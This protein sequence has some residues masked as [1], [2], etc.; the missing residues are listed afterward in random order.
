M[1]NYLHQ[2][3]IFY[4]LL[5]EFCLQL[6][7]KLLISRGMENINMLH[8]FFKALTFLLFSLSSLLPMGA[9]A[10]TTTKAK[11]QL[12]ITV[13]DLPDHGELPAGWT[14]E[15]LSAKFLAAFK[16]HHLTGVYGFV[17]SHVINEDKPELLHILEEWHAA[18]QKL[19]NHTYSHMD[20]NSSSLKDFETDILKN[21]VI[22][23]KLAPPEEF[24]YLRF[25]FLSEGKTLQN[26]RDLRSFLK[27]HE[28]KVAPITADFHDWRWNDAFPRCVKH[29]RKAEIAQLKVK[30]IEKALKALVDAEKEM[31]GLFARPVKHIQL[32]HF[33]AFDAMMMD[34]LLTAYEKAGVEFIS[35]DEALQDPIF[36]ESSPPTPDTL[37]DM[38]EKELG[39]IEHGKTEQRIDTDELAEEKEFDS[40]CKPS[41]SKLFSTKV[42]T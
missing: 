14:Y 10:Q 11:L 41:L 32:L 19:G 42:K 25:P 26:F 35:L 15:E 5:N 28:Y 1:V 18:G 31:T 12:A 20:F 36:N 39:S 9:L 38:T 3:S 6:N 37:R 34:E 7:V 4:Y 24:K 21:E 13:D 27:E 22:L 29:N 17:N 23:S 2:I 30:F 8:T 16:A 40:Y 33:G